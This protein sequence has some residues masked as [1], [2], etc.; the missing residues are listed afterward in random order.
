MP[1][2]VATGSCRRQNNR[3]IGNAPLGNRHIGDGDI[4]AGQTAANGPG[5]K[6]IRQKWWRPS[7]HYRHSTKCYS[8]H[9]SQLF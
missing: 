7:I 1:M 5:A 6:I 2:S 3:H 9:K 4:G 8:H